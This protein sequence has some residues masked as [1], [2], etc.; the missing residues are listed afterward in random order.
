MTRR[1]SWRNMA[2]EG[3]EHLWLRVETTGVRAEAVVIGSEEGTGF[4]LRYEIDLDGFW[5][6][7]RI[8]ATL[9]GGE[10][11]LE[12]IGAGPGRWLDGAGRPLP[13][14]DGCV[15]VDISATPFTN[16]PFI[17]RLD[18]A[19]LEAQEARVAYVSVPSLEC[20]AVTQRYVC[21][22][23]GRRYRYAGYP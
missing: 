2:S 22:E 11:R 21:L 20:R 13:R 4:G 18:L 23:R 10:S 15:D 5:R 6:P 14:L 3:L 16:T 7:L 8:R 17:R 1:V 9:V 12:L 19:G